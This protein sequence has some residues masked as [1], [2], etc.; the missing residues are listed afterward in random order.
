MA[1]GKTKGLQTKAPNPRHAAKA[2]ASTKRGKRYIAPKKPTLVKQASLKKGLT[3]K[4]N[5]SIEE[6]MVSAASGGKLT[7]M[8]NANAG[9]STSKK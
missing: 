8:K 2:A 1:Q 3:A 6:Q 9:P 4:I 7:I 5:K